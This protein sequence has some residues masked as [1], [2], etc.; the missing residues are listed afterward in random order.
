MTANGTAAPHSGVRIGQVIGFETTINSTGPAPIT[1]LQAALLWGNA[2]SRKVL[3]TFTSGDVGLNQV[4]Q[5]FEF[6]LSWPVNDSVTGLNGTQ[7]RAFTVVFTWNPGNVTGLSGVAALTENVTIQPSQVVIV[8]ISLP[9]QSLDISQMYYSYGVLRYNGSQAATL[10]LFATP[11]SGGGSAILIAVGTSTQGNFTLIWYPLNQG[12]NSALSP[13]TSYTLEAVATYNTATGNYSLPGVYTVPGSTSPT[14]FLFETFLG[15]PLWVWLAIAAGAAIAIVAVLFLLRRQAAGKVVECGECGNLIPED[16]TVCPKCGAEFESDLVR[17]SRCASTIPANS[18][19]APS[20]PRSCSG[21]RLGPRRGRAPGLPG[22]HREVPGRGEEGARRE[23]HRGL[24]L[25]LVEAPGDVRLLQPVEAPA[26]PGFAADGND[27]AP[28]GTAR[29]AARL[30]SAAGA[31]TRGRAPDRCRAGGRPGRCPRAP[32]S[33]A[34]A[35]LGKAP[36]PAPGGL[37]ACPSCQ[38]EIP[39]DYLVCPFCGSVTQ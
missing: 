33:A 8:S 15:L 36:P 31:R 21:S 13:G 10:E 34:A 24:V 1:S 19:S 16:A 5:T 26:G 27:R 39:G 9:P 35:P 4:G 28:R 38:K 12:G 17:C 18:P 14:S 25:G 7:S 23:L 32:P 29:C 37:K 30:D 3:A 20:A 2:S 22:L 6:T 11:T